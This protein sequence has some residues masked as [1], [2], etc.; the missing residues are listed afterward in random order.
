[1]TRQ[2]LQLEGPTKID[3][4]W[5]GQSTWL[6]LNKEKQTTMDAEA[7]ALF[8]ENPCSTCKRKGMDEEE[9]LLCD[10]CVWW[11]HLQCSKV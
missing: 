5:Q 1:M 4:D 10:I 3:S 2:A 11:E 9:A 7:A 6:Q 8:K